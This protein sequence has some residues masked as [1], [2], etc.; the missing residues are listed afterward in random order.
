MGDVST[1]EVGFT[2]VEMLAA[3]AVFGVMTFLALP[4]LYN[5]SNTFNRV[6]AKSYI[7]QDLKRAQAETITQGC[8]GILAV[9]ASA[10]GYNF[11]CD[12]LAYDASATPAADKTFFSRSLP[13]RIT[14]S[15]S[16]PIILNSRGQTVDAA[17]VLTTVT[18]Q[19]WEEV[20][21]VPT[22]FATGTLSGTGVFSF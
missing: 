14:V 17:D 2:V 3:I 5:L 21:G 15:V 12:Y 11:G 7:V 19:L 4:H 20:N 13:E 16:G 9:D 8:R 1:S 22:A 6:N 18:I 10:Q